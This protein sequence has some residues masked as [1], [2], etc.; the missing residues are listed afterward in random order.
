MT[1]SKQFQ[2]KHYAWL[3]WLIL[4]FVAGSLL[5]ACANMTAPKVYRVG[6]LAGSNAFNDAVEGF[7]AEMTELGYVEG[8]TISYDFQSADGD[9]EMMKQIAEKFVADEVDLIFTTTTG[10]AQAAQ[11]AT[12][13]TAI[14]V[15]FTVVADPVGS[16]LVA[17]LREPGGNITG[18]TRS[19][20][21]II[22]K[23]VVFLHQM[24][25]EVHR[26]WLPYQEG[27][28][29][30]DLT[31]EAIQEGALAEGFDLEIIE[32]PVSGPEA[33]VAELAKRA[34]ADDP[35][36]DAILIA[37]DPTMQNEVTMEAVIAF[38]NDHNLP[39]VGNTQDQVRQGALLTYADNSFETGQQAAPLADKIF[40][41][42]E[43]GMLPVT[44]SEPH[45]YINYNVAQ[46]LGLTVDETLL[47][48][49]SEVIR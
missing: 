10:A 37:P 29:N 13:G 4:V 34:E 15:V 2:G 31:R 16:G 39:V 44:F 38:A 24:A 20:A 35:G 48:Q 43:P 46:A 12:A 19:L 40:K 21:G 6:F 1:E 41:G 32:T 3:R 5:T 11:A 23:R 28:A 42:T 8:E 25:P 14:P 49:A 17:D 9:S 47:A 22:S 45:L 26:L 18:A 30:V 7:K 27:Y 36:F 33:V